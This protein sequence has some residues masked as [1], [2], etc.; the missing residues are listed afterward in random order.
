MENM[1]DREVYVYHA[2]VN[3]AIME[4]TLTVA[5]EDMEVPQNKMAYAM[6]LM[7]V[8]KYVKSGIC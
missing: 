4:A 7:D 1:T 5:A 6:L 3:L 8:E 2:F